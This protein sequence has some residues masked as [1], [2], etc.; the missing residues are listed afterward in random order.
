MKGGWRPPFG[1][2]HAAL[3]LG[4]LT[5]G[6]FV[7]SFFMNGMTGH[8]PVTFSNLVMIPGFLVLIAAC[9]DGDVSGKKGLLRSTGMI[10]LGQWSYA[11]YLIHELVI[12]MVRGFAAGASV[13]ESAVLAAFVVVTSVVLSGFLHELVE[14]PAERWL[15][16]RRTTQNP[17][18]VQHS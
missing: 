8:L 13:G 10:R 6:L 3:F 18:Q 17:Q 5:A 12:R 4:S 16:R 2:A 14:K 15:R 1:G 9:A 11:L 7:A